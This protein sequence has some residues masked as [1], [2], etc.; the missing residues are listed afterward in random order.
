M[1]VRFGLLVFMSTLVSVSAFV[2]AEF[3]NGPLIK[4]YG[5]NAEIAGR[6]EIPADA[7]FQVAFDITDQ[8]KEGEVSRKLETAARFLNMHV[9]AGVPADNI[10][11][12]LVIHSRAIHDVANEDFWKR[13]GNKVNV[14]APLVAELIKH[15][16]E[17]HVCGQSAANY[18]VAT[19]DLLPGVKMSLSAMTTHALLQ[20]RGYTL[21]PF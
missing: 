6:T 15:G 9:R 13:H 10:K 16:V 5:P 11:L 17:I 3:S 4:G 2:Q 18:Q 14:N 19:E 1:N 7:R 20:Q 12:A 21:N 8:A